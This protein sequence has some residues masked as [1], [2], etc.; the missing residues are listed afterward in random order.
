MYVAR[1]LC[2]LSIPLGVGAVVCVINVCVIKGEGIC[3]ISSVFFISPEYTNKVDKSRHVSSLISS[4][5]LAAN[6][7]LRTFVYTGF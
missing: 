1:I 2:I 4:C 5:A 7:T 6:L 3:R